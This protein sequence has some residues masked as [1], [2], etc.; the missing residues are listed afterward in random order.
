MLE[1]E[2]GTGQAWLMALRRCVVAGD[3]SKH[4]VVFRTLL[5]CL[6]RWTRTYDQRINRLGTCSFAL[7]LTLKSSA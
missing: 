6:R 3:P 4:A 5:A 2:D 7:T 1:V